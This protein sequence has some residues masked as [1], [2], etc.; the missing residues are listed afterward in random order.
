MAFYL[1]VDC[2]IQAEI[3]FSKNSFSMIKYPPKPPGPQDNG[4][5]S[6]GGQ[7]WTNMF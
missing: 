2:A 3:S 5:E 1:S 6:S 7:N 4:I